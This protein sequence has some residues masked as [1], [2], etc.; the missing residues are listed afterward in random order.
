MMPIHLNGFGLHTALGRGVDA[1][2]AALDRAPQP[3][4]EVPVQLASG[5]R[6]IPYYVLAD[7]P[8]ENIEARFEYVLHEV[9]AEA[10]RR[11]GVSQAERRTM[12][13]FLGSSCGEMPVC[14]AQY[15]RDLALSPDA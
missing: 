10:L 5:E 12:G 6:G 8:L 4:R 9:I 11:S 15:R 2:L 1:N 7:A 13:F 14:E 3:P